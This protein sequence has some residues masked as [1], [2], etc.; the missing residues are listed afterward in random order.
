VKNTFYF[1]FKAS[2]INDSEKLNMQITKVV[3]YI[4]KR[5]SLQKY[6]NVDLLIGTINDDFILNIKRLRVKFME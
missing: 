5:Y 1:K 2:K 3:E 6:K 4:S